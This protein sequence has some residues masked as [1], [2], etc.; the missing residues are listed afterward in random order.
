LNFEQ[1]LANRALFEK[2][3]QTELFWKEALLKRDKQGYLANVW[4]WFFTI[5]RL[6][7]WSSFVRAL[8]EKRPEKIG[9]FCSRESGS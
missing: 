1:C 5:L 2:S 6:F 8:L 9:L 4:C 7:C 3:L